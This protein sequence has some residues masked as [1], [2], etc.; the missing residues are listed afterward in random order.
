MVLQ[1]MASIL[2]IKEG[3]FGG[4]AVVFKCD[5][6]GKKA[7]KRISHFREV[8]SHYCSRACF[9]AKVKADAKERKDYDYKYMPLEARIA[10]HKNKWL[11][12]SWHVSQRS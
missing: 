11:C 1:K 3:Q 5:Y 8:D 6:C 12:K 4:K 10:K 9:T 2:E 7:E